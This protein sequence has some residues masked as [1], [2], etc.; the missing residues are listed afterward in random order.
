MG[1]RI[2][3][4][5]P[6]INALALQ[7][8]PDLAREVRAGGLF[9]GEGVPGALFRGDVVD[10]ITASGLE[11]IPGSQERGFRVSHAG[12]T[13]GAEHEIDKPDACFCL[14]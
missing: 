10:E 14:K 13:E 3:I 11:H 9:D 7:R 4:I 6:K 12:E 1:G 8:L 2:E 5:H